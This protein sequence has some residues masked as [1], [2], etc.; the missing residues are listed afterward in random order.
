MAEEGMS[1]EGTLRN[2]RSE[3]HIELKVANLAY[4]ECVS[5]DFMPSW[6]KGEQL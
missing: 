5:K 3:E 6:L 4:T 1:F 2:L